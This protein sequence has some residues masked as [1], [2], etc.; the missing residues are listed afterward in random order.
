MPRDEHRLVRHLAWV[1][2]IK[3]LALGGLWWVFVRDQR[4]STDA[5]AAAQHLAAPAPAPHQGEPR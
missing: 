4:I 1:L 5:T 3:L 2:V